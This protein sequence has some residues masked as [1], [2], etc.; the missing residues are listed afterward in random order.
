[1]SRVSVLV[2]CTL[3]V[4][5]A[6]PPARGAGTLF[7]SRCVGGCSY[8][9]ALD[10]SACLNKSSLIS[11]TRSLSAYSGSDGDWADLLA[12]VRSVLDSFDV[13]VTDVD[14]GC[15]NQWEIPVAGTASQ[16]GFPDGV[17]GVAPFG[18]CQVHP[19]NV[20]FVF[21][22]APE[23]ANVS[24]LCWTVVHEFAH[25]IAIDHEVL[26]RDPMSYFEGCFVKR[27]SPVASPC[28]TGPGNPQPCFCTAG[29]QS[30]FDLLTERLGKAP[31]LLFSD[32]FETV[33]AEGDPIAGES[34]HWDSVLGEELPPPF[35]RAAGPATWCATDVESARR[36]R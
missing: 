15:G 11:G 22:N 34:C 25:L 30:S 31:G 17:L 13:E 2:G 18:D 24:E 23:H 6:A 19:N 32:T 14:P 33:Q 26:E 1:M 36:R 27:F 3:L 16:V 5:L 20:A 29:T 8:S 21:A 10:N 4:V 7:L 28:G 9:G 12:C 35:A